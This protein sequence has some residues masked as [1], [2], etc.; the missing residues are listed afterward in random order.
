MLTRRPAVPADAET[1]LEIYVAYDTLEFG[2][3]EMELDDLE[4]M[5]ALPDSD[6]VI[7]AD[8]GRVVGFA[9]VSRNG[10]VETLVDPAY[11]G[12]EQVQRDLLA[13]VVE[14]STAR[15]VGRIE[16][17]AGAAPERAGALLSEAGFEHVRTIWRMGRAVTGELPEPQ[18][19]A[20]VQLREFDRERD[21]REVWQ[22]VMTSFAGTY[23][24]HERPFE[25]WSTLVLDHGYTVL[26]AVEHG[27][28]VAVATRGTRNG[29]GHV[30]QL[31]VLPEQRGR[32]LAV[33][34]LLES[35]RRDAAAGHSRTTLTVDG[36]ND[37]A[38]RLYEGVG[39][40]VEAEYRRWERD[41]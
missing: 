30:G 26:C 31:A 12:A 40:T 18:W 2:Q 37:R 27:A 3:P 14:Q 38:R 41:V 22:V 11:D 16:H 21:A 35:F 34:L 19:P 39:M 4:G 1:L 10:E 33:A 28:M 20:G 13:W 8:D 25:E 7:V 9:D 32:G 5:L 29:D 17:F 15:G 23:G 24:S 6:H 36:E